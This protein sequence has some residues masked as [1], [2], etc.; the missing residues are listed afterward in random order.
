[1]TFNPY[2]APEP[3]PD[4][5]SARPRM[6]LPAGIG[7]VVASVFFVAAYMS[8][9]LSLTP[10]GR[11]VPRWPVLAVPFPRYSSPF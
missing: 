2:E 4:D 3:R 6:R 1:M 11:P 10:A 5:Q 7:Y 8:I 9:T